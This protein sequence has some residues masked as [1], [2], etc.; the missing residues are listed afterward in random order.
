MLRPVVCVL[1][2][3]GFWTCSAALAPDLEG[4]TTPREGIEDRASR[5]YALRGLDV[6]VSPQQRLESATIVVRDGWIHAVG[7]IEAPAGATVVDLSGYVATAGWIDLDHRVDVGPGPAPPAESPSAGS[8]PVHEG[9]PGQYWNDFVRPEASAAD[10]APTAEERRARREAGFTLSV[11]SRDGGVLSGSGTLI[12]LGEESARHPRL[13]YSPIASFGSFEDR[14]WQSRAYPGSRMG[15]I[16][17]MRQAFLDAQWYRDGLAFALRSGQP[18]PGLDRSLAAL[19]PVLAGELPFVVR[20]R[21]PLELLNAVSLTQEF[22]LE[23]AWYN[24]SGHE[25]TWIDL[26]APHRPRLVIPVAFPR[27]PPVDLV[28]DE[29]EISLRALEM[30]ARAPE[31]PGRLERAGV[32]FALTPRGLDAIDDFYVRVQEACERG[33]SKATALGALTTLPAGWIGF[34]QTLGT[35]EPGKRASFTILS[36]PIFDEGGRVHE[37]WI[38]GVR[39]P[40]GLHPPRDV[41]GRWA[42]TLGPH[43]YSATIEGELSKP[44]I[45]VRRGTTLVSGAQLRED[46][47]WFAVTLAGETAADSW[48]LNWAY[49]VKD[50]VWSG[51]AFD[52]EGRE[53]PFSA[54]RLTTPP[55]STPPDSESSAPADSPTASTETRSRPPTPPGHVEDRLARP[56]GSY[57][58][59]EPRYRPRR[60][61]VRGASV[62]TCGPEGVLPSGELLV[63]D[64]KI[65][66]V[67]TDLVATGVDAVIDL[68]GAHITPGIIDAHSHTAIIGGVNEGT[69]AVTS[70]V[71][72]ADVVD[73]DDINIY[74]ELAGGVTVAQLLH[75]SANPIGGQAATIKLR[76]GE[77]PAAM[78]LVGA[79]P[80]IKFALGE[81]VKQ[82]NWGDEFVTR[83]PQTRMGVEQI[84][85][86]SFLAAREYQTRLRQGRGVGAPWRRDLELDALVEI[87]E[88]KRWI[89]CHS[90]RQDEILALIRVA[91]DFGFRVG[92]FQHVLEGYKVAR[93]IARHGAGGS[94]FSDWWAFKF[95]VYDAI[96]HN[97]A[98]LHRAGVT[99]SF[100]SDSDELARRLNTEAAKA[101]KYGGVSREEALCFVTLYPARQLGI[102]HLVGSLE[103]GKDADF[104]IWS[105]D[106]LSTYS[107]CLETWID[108]ARYF[109]RDEEGE[110]RRKDRDRRT[111]LVQRALEAAQGDGRSGGSA[112]A[113]KEKESYRCCP[114]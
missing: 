28:S 21:D 74:R 22:G 69:Q 57:G 45:Q 102:D 107:L 76:W 40:R 100:N 90:Y 39:Y 30:W 3:L 25:F 82:S 99:T 101:V 96:P 111:F 59:S 41:R 52:G 2:T 17:L 92:T 67:G 14:G 56:L 113:Q 108:G 36:G 95:E 104:V 7:V 20:T 87:L 88:G 83:Y 4:Q 68:P 54:N 49:G 8:Q 50:D 64:G 32:P 71:R 89:H 79:K 63:E 80:T 38:D 103:P 93:E 19:G 114:R 53:V 77:G 109:S 34:E 51:T 94:S 10:W 9:F 97:G 46:A 55:D 62:W 66:A 110:I 78:L 65:V 84:L 23:R 11:V 6:W 35:I 24:G 37:V 33:L 12:A 5:V 1:A 98:L 72:I 85:R 112:P 42:F 47:G 106:P 73:P 16:A 26:L 27:A 60:L 44:S 29:R 43:T 70:E 13:R 81:N 75:G 31:N 18:P 61:L 105:G 15:A 48:R 86:D 91:E 58:R